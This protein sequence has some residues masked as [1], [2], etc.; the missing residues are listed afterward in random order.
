LKCKNTRRCSTR[1]HTLVRGKGCFNSVKWE[2]Y[3][4]EGKNVKEFND[5]LKGR[6]KVVD[7]TE[8]EEI[9]KQLCPDCQETINSDKN[10]LKSSRLLR[11]HRRLCPEHPYSVINNT[12]K[13]R[14]GQGMQEKIKLPAKS[15]NDINTI[16]KI[17]EKT[18]SK[19]YNKEKSYGEFLQGSKNSRESRQESHHEQSGDSLQELGQESRVEQSGDPHQEHAQE[20]LREQ[21]QESCLEQSGDPHHESPQ[22]HAWEPPIQQHQESSLQQESCLQKDQESCLQKDQESRLQHYEEL[23]LRQDQESCLQQDQDSHDE[24]AP[25]SPLEQEQ[26]VSS[27]SKSP[28]SELLLYLDPADDSFQDPPYVP[29]EDDESNESDLSDYIKVK[30]WYH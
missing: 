26:D 27:I 1:N 6:G 19:F 7:E 9:P 23:N 5:K 18:K 25:G 12:R 22:E 2:A 17:R 21:S 13:L 30:T 14:S 29:N 3:V 15:V 16:K 24:M 11:E 20:S 4:E 8:E 28:S 10:K